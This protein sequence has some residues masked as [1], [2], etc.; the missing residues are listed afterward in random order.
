M[1]I[2]Q[3]E[4]CRSGVETSL[5]II[6]GK[7]KPI[8]L[9]HL[10]HGGTKRFGELKRLLPD[11]TQKMLTTQLR[12]LEEQDIITRKV[13]P[14]VPPRVE[15]SVTEYGRGLYGILQQMYE[16]GLAHLEHM[17]KKKS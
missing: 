11:I 1:E 15:Y 8:I 5:E 10:L 12:E 4:T 3:P 13:Y 14:E 7:W 2:K 16:W 9:L 17:A 6:V